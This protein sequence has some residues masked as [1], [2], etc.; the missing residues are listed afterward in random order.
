MEFFL[1]NGR[2]EGGFRTLWD[3]RSAGIKRVVGAR[4]IS[5]NY[6]VGSVE[7][8]DTGSAMYPDH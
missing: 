3:A 4:E 6:N 8:G 1:E 2:R 5:R 7:R